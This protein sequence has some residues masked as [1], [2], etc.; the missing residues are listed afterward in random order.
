[1]VSQAGGTIILD[2]FQGICILYAV[3]VCILGLILIIRAFCL[4]AEDTFSEIQ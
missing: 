4:T 2:I 3:I 1:M